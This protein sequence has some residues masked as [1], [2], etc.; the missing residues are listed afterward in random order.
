[1]LVLLIGRRSDRLRWHDMHIKFRDDW[2]R[3]LSNIE[4]LPQQLRAC[5]VGITKGRDL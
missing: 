1:V 5:N 3:Y 4:V 2:Y